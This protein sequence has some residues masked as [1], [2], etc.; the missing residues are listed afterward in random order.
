VHCVQADELPLMDGTAT[1]TSAK[2]H[3]LLHQSVLVYRLVN[4]Q[5]RRF[6]SANEVGLGKTIETALILGE[7]FSLFTECLPAPLQLPILCKVIR[8]G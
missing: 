3:L 7:L 1:L 8:D 5:L 6:L 4:T 2:V